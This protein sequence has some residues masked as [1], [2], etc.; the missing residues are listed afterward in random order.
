VTNLK[1]ARVLVIV[2]V[3]ATISA[4]RPTTPPHWQMP[5]MARRE[6]EIIIA[7]EEGAAILPFTLS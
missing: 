1:Q 7:F 2:T 4:L 5:R 6:I 3:R